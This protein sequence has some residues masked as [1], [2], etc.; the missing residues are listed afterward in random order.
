MPAAPPRRRRFRYSLRTLLIV[1]TLIG[2]WLAVELN[3]IREKTHAISML[4][5]WGAGIT[6]DYEWS[7]SGA[8]IPNAQ[9]PGLQWLKRLLGSHYRS[10]VVKVELFVERGMTPEK[11]NDENAH[12]LSA[13]TEVDWLMLM[14]T[15]IGDAGLKHLKGLKKLGRLDLEGTRVTSEGVH[16][17]CDALPKVRVFYGTYPQPQMCAGA[18]VDSP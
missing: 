4:K 13:L 7:A 10:N 9:P 18:E 1:V 3:R 16:E 17:L 6:Y 8:Y 11:L 5:A 2:V 14:D 12:L 15:N